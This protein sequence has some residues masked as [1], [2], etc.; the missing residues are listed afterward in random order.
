MTKE[1][2]WD[3]IVYWTILRL[4]QL[5][6]LCGAHADMNTTQHKLKH[7]CHHF[8]QTATT[9][10]LQVINDCGVYIE[11]AGTMPILRK[12]MSINI[13]KES[14]W[15]DDSRQ[16]KAGPRKFQFFWYDKC[17]PTVVEENTAPVCNIHAFFCA[18]LYICVSSV[19]AAYKGYIDKELQ[20]LNLPGSDGDGDGAGK[21]RKAKPVADATKG[22]LF[23][24][25]CDEQYDRYLE[26]DEGKLLEERDCKWMNNDGQLKSDRPPVPNMSVYAAKFRFG[27][28]MKEFLVAP[29][30]CESVF[31]MTEMV[32]IF[33]GASQVVR[34]FGLA[35]LDD[36]LEGFSIKDNIYQALYDPR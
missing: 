10:V 8:V 17:V 9:C 1:W 20:K 31:T 29:W 18:L 15:P 33:L 6:G 30:T 13:H 34:N 19:A 26:T 24:V 14:D 5:L 27:P 25:G 32:Y 16:S 35:T 21:T 28:E 12:L 23:L 3:L 7:V 36:A 4:A 11:L 22:L 2:P